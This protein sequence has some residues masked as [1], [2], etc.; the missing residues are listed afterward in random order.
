MGPV[1]LPSPPPERL[2]AGPGAGLRAPPAPPSLA[3]LTLR[4]SPV[5]GREGAAGVAAA[6]S[7]PA[8]VKAPGPVTAPALGVW[9]PPPAP[10]LLAPDGR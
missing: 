4:P 7:W 3:R 5:V 2:R 9:T 6:R 1:A 8:P 10:P